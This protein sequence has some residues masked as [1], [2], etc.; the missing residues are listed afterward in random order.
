M[1]LN[2][3]NGLVHLQK[4]VLIKNTNA[5]FVW[6]KIMLVRAR[7]PYIKMNHELE[8]SE[9]YLN[10]PTSLA[11]ITQTAKTPTASRIPHRTVFSSCNPYPQRTI[12]ALKNTRPWK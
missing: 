6:H 3:L 1:L 4:I 12:L 11:E 7:Y 10:M 2:T 9:S 5:Q 8:C